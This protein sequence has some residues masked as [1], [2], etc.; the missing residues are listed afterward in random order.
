MILYNF[1]CDKK[2][3]MTYKKIVQEI[4]LLIIDRVIN[5]HESISKVADSFQI[6]QSTVSMM[7][8]RYIRNNNMFLR[9]GGYKKPILNQPEVERLLRF[10]DANAD[11]T[12]DDMKQ[13]VLDQFGKEVSISTIYEYLKK[14]KYSFKLIRLV[15]EKRNSIEVINQRY[16]WASKFYFMDKTSL[17]FV[18][19]AGFNLQL[20]RR[21]GWSSSNTRA[22]VEVPSIKGGNISIVGAVSLNGLHHFNVK[23]GAF[24]TDCFVTFCEKLCKTLFIQGQEH[25]KY[26]ILMDNVPFHHSQRV[27]DVFEK[28]GY[29]IMY[30]PSY[31]PFL[32]LI[33]YAWSSWKFPIK[34]KCVLNKDQLLQEIV[35]SHKT[36]TSEKC[37]SWFN[38]IEE[39]IPLCLAKSEINS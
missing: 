19:E 12:I 18:D 7:L 27:K 33:E 26:T 3:H 20:K 5:K 15:P 9:R 31:S 29:N 24:N 21:C 13:Y 30:L 23:E 4:K 17:V 14:S 37:E 16:D 38:K 6:N 39:Y 28:F 2:V 25:V 11:V 36:V 10:V 22:Y 34:K 8:K 1:N 35:E 32:N